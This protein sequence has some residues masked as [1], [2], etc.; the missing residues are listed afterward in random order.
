MKKILTLISILIIAYS[1]NAQEL[2]G[3]YLGSYTKISP[4]NSKVTTLVGEP[5]ALSTV[6]LK[7]GKVAIVIAIPIDKYSS[8]LSPRNVKIREIKSLTDALAEKYKVKFEFIPKEAD[9]NQIGWIV[10][11]VSN[12]RVQI[13]I[14]E[15]NKYTDEYV[16]GVSIRD[17][18]LDAKYDLE[19]QNDL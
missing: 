18:V 13:N 6:N 8:W 9:N 1:L 10:G 11:E 7:N 17:K 5:Y 4:E 14:T 2:K 3:I 15:Y 19:V 12:L 16:I